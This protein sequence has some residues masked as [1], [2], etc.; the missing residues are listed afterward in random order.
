MSSGDI[1]Y[2]TNDTISWFDED[3]KIVLL[4]IWRCEHNILKQANSQYL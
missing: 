2:K 4:N 1:K 3:S